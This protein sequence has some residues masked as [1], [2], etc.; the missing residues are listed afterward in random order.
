M[1]ELCS[2]R[3]EETWLGALY[4]GENQEELPGEPSRGKREALENV[5]FVLICA[6]PA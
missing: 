4:C 3:L 5:W 1:A 2:L 6:N